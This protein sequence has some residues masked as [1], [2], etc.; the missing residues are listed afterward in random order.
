M[1]ILKYKRDKNWIKIIEA[2][3]RVDWLSEDL[4][5]KTIA[6][7]TYKMVLSHAHLTFYRYYP[8]G[9]CT[10]LV[11]Y[12]DLFPT[13]KISIGLFE[14]FGYG[15]LPI[16]F[17]LRLWAKASKGSIFLVLSFTSIMFGCAIIFGY[18]GRR[19]IC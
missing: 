12:R 3:Q 5:Y 16:K 10:W 19:V 11:S 17:R 4:G 1:N 18:S 7:K 15:C 13:D 2:N 6:F 14:F 8:S 9:L